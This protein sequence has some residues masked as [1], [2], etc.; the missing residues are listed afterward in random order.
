MLGGHSGFQETNVEHVY[1]GIIHDPHI[2][3]LTGM[4]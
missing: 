3:P 2:S 4:P 1:L